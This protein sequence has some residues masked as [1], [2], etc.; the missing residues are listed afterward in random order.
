MSRLRGRSPFGVAK[1]RPSTLLQQGACPA[2]KTRSPWSG[3]TVPIERPAEFT[4]QRLNEALGIHHTD[5]RPGGAVRDRVCMRAVVGE[6]ILDLPGEPKQLA[7]IVLVAGA[8]DA[9]AVVLRTRENAEP[10]AGPD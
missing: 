5:D 3:S 9:A 4:A 6:A 1:A 7:Q 8:V 2:C 10:F